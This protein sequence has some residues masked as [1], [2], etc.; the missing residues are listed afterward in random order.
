[1]YRYRLFVPI[2]ALVQRASAALL[3]NSNIKAN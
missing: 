1:M 2:V 3:L